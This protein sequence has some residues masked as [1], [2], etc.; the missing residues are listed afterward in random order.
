[1]M[2]FS[3]TLL[4]I[5]A[6]LGLAAACGFRVFVPLFLISLASRSELIGLSEGFQWIG[7]TPALFCFATATVLELCAYY[8]PVVDNLLDT[9]AT[10]AAIVAGVVVAAAV[11]TDID[12]WLKWT[13]ATVAGGGLAAAVQIPTV[14]ARGMSTSMTAGLG[15]PV[16][17]SGEFVAAGMFS[18]AAIFLPL[19]LPLLVLAAVVLYARRLR[20]RV[21]VAIKD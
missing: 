16:V 9:L 6:A 10:P 7:S 5:L 8:I 2:E 13:L 20:R 21:P 17:S 19:L 18:G 4:S 1:M 12:P 3:T 14:A 11:M 15:N